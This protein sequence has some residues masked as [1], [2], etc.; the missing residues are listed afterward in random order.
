MKSH[1]SSYTKTSINKLAVCD[2][3]PEKCL[4]YHSA[5]CLINNPGEHWSCWGAPPRQEPD[6]QLSSGSTKRSA[7]KTY[8]L[9]HLEMAGGTHMMGL[10]LAATHHQD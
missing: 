1:H 6:I 8:K 10:L 3:L 9:Q 2:M 4:A 7:A 5:T